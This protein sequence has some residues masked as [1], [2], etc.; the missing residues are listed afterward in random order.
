MTLEEKLRAFGE[1]DPDEHANEAEQNWGGTPQF[2]ESMRRT[3]AYTADD[4]QEMRRNQDEIYARFVALMESGES[5]NSAAAAEM[6]DEHR[7]HISQWFYECT[8]EIHSGLGEMYM[9]DDRF[10]TNIDKSGKGLAAY[11][12]S[13]IRARYATA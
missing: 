8:P 13:A 2:A 7:D 9:T 1:F 10:K 11:L 12:S 5:A 4:W 6:V 3:T